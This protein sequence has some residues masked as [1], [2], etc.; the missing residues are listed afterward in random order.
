MP[1]QSGRFLTSNNSDSD[2]SDSNSVEEQ[3]VPTS[4][5]NT[6]PIVP[7]SIPI[8]QM[9][10][11]VVQEQPTSSN[12]DLSSPTFSSFLMNPS[13]FFSN[14]P[15]LKLDGS[16]FSDWIMFLCTFSVKYYLPMIP[17]ILEFS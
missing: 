5:A 13:K 17:T 12:F 2:S 9:D 8:E 10:P 6:H 4:S 14:A 16:K 11:K 1:L 3:L 7:I 15:K